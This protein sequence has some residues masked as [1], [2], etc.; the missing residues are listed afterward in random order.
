ML[1]FLEISMFTQ[2]E[3]KELL[4]YV[5]N[6]HREMRELIEKKEVLPSSIT[7]NGGMVGATIEIR[8]IYGREVKNGKI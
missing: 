5:D 6:V 8:K 2:A 7:H 3:R 4:E 1:A